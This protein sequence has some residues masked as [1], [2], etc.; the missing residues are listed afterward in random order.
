MKQWLIVE[1]TGV[2]SGL[3][4]E[5]IE[6][7]TQRIAEERRQRLRDIH[8][9]RREEKVDTPS[10]AINFSVFCDPLFLLIVFRL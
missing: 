5:E 4:A 1:A 6:E 8:T 9:R 10:I 3:T 2:N 7:R